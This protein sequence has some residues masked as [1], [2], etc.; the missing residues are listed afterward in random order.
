MKARSVIIRLI[1]HPITPYILLLFFTIV[2]VSPIFTS[3]PAII[4]FALFQK[5]IIEGLV[6]G[7][8]KM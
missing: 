8:I 7:A 2:M 4:F 6:K 3:L 1:E 5:Y